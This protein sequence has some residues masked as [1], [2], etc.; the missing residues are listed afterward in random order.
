[1]QRGD[2]EVF[3]KFL[4]SIEF[5]ADVQSLASARF[6]HFDGIINVGAHRC[7]A[8]VVVKITQAGGQARISVSVTIY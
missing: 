1:M 5:L 8:P 2:W 4:A 6:C 3:G 7:Q